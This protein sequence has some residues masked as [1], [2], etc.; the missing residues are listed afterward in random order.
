MGNQSSIRLGRRRAA[1][2]VRNGAGHIDAHRT[3]ALIA[4]PH[5]RRRAVVSTPYTA[6]SL[7]RAVGTAH[8]RGEFGIAALAERFVEALPAQAGILSRR[9][10][11]RAHERR[12]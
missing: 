4:E 12:C 1:D 6:V 9:P 11:F 2:G 8:D 5:M 10:P 3:P 7:L